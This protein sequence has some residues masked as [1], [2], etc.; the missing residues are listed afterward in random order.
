MTPADQARQ[1]G[2]SLRGGDAAV[3]FAGLGEAR[4]RLAALLAEGSP[5]AF[6]RIALDD[7][8][9]YVRANETLGRALEA[10]GDKQ[11]ACEAYAA[12]LA[13]WGGATPRSTTAERTK[14]RV[15]ALGCSR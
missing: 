4:S 2:G 5:A 12:V 14:A 9:S 7:P 10:K 6:G 1:L 15:A 13:R 8:V 3:L 11:G